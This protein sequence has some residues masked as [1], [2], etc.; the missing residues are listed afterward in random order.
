[1]SGRASAKTLVNGRPHANDGKEGQY[2]VYGHALPDQ[3]DFPN[4]CHTLVSHTRHDSPSTSPIHRLSDSLL[5]EIFAQHV[6]NLVIWPPSE[7]DWWAVVIHVCHLWREVAFRTPGLWTSIS[8]SWHPELVRMFIAQ[9]GTLP[10]RIIDFGYYAHKQQYLIFAQALRLRNLTLDSEERFDQFVQAIHGHSAV[11]HLQELRLDFYKGSRSF[12]DLSSISMPGLTSLD[13][14]R[15][16]AASI[17]SL[18]RPTV[19]SL[20]LHVMPSQEETS[21]SD[22][23]NLLAGL[24]AL[25]SLSLSESYRPDKR[26]RAEARSASLPHLEQLEMIGTRLG[27]TELLEHLTL[28]ATTCFKFC[29]SERS[30]DGD[31]ALASTIRTSILVPACNAST[32]LSAPKSAL[33]NLHFSDGKEGSRKMSLVIKMWSSARS[34]EDLV[35]STQWQ[36]QGT[37]SDA[38]LAL[39]IPLMESRLHGFIKELTSDVDLSCVSSMYISCINQTLATA[40]WKAL[41]QAFPG[42]QNLALGNDAIHSLTE[43]TRRVIYVPES[44]APLPTGPLYPS[45][46][47]LRLVRVRW[48]NCLK[49][50]AYA[51]TRAALVTALKSLAREDGLA[52][53]RLEIAEPENFTQSDCAALVREGIARTVDVRDWGDESY[54]EC[55]ASARH[56]GE[57]REDMKDRIWRIEHVLDASDDSDESWGYTRGEA[58]SDDEDWDED[59]NDDD[60]DGTDPRIVWLPHDDTWREEDE[61]ESEDDDDDSEGVIIYREPFIPNITVR[62][63]SPSRMEEEDDDGSETEDEEGW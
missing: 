23:M 14:L 39:K 35:S 42:I 11:P 58:E 37:K 33:I 30:R 6:A 24:P 25:H 22:L 59:E 28:Q 18:I 61:D 50:D 7:E 1:M 31:K 8:A 54:R 53:N 20:S 5:A 26:H 49:H 43:G 2:D 13:I 38:K 16:S 55:A 29:S 47:V 3:E 15:A 62:R 10:L 34:L 9:S 27:F 32:A 40:D 19:T 44:S 45:L 60:Y 63:L 4:S 21:L 52:L 17:Q 48:V 41:L 56:R 51:S 36:L 57:S 46:E 12:P